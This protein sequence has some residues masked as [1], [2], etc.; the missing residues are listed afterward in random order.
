MTKPATDRLKVNPPLGMMPALQYLLPVQLNIDTS[1][2]RSLDTDT[3]RTL[4]R[5]IAQHWNWDLCQ[6]LVVSRRD[7]GML[8]VIDGQHRLAAARLRGDIQQLPAVVVQYASAAD[9]AGSFVNLNQ[10]RRPLTKIDIFKA[11]VASGDTEST[12]ILAVI[13]AAGLTIAPHSNPTTWKPGMVSNIGGLEACWRQ[14]GGKV[15]R[16]ACKALSE[17]FFGQVMRYAGTVFPGIAA[18]VSLETQ[19][20]TAE[21][22][23]MVWPVFIEMVRGQEQEYWRTEIMRARADDPNLKFS[24]ASE[25]VFTKAWSEVLA[26]MFDGE[27]EGI[28]PAIPCL[29]PAAQKPPVTAPEKPIPRHPPATPA[30]AIPATISRKET[31]APFI[32]KPAPKP[33]PAPNVDTSVRKGRP[34][35]PPRLFGSNPAKPAQTFR[36]DE[37]GK[38]WCSQCDRRKT[39]AEV[40]GCPDNFCPFKERR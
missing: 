9:E 4:V 18:V 40:S 23:D 35:I 25:Q 34:V 28:D 21:F 17:S 26:E 38:G 20:G 7:D 1:Y 32:P 16:L 13:H 30:P 14:R 19:D 15:T 31:V 12:Q 6:P 8:Y 24:R 37:E 11:A 29:P 10:Q 27:G 5:S 33:V 39:A 36:S 2:Q 3:S 22:D